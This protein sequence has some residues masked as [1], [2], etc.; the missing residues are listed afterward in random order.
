MRINKTIGNVDIKLDTK[1]LDRNMM[2]AQKL[3]NLA[4]RTDCEPLVPVLSGDLRRKAWFP[5]GVYGGVLEYNSMYA[6]YQYVGEVYGPNIPIRD[7]E[8]NITRWFSPK[9]KAKN[10]TGRKMAK[11]SQ[12]GTGPEWFE[13]AKER[14]GDKWLR[15]V[16]EE[17]GKG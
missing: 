8:G 3:L 1:R 7:S 16:R 5:D 11:Y 15:L 2:N 6:H 13:K 9:G 12:S 14:H 4:V 17:A 10:P